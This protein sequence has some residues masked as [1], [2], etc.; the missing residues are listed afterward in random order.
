MCKIAS[1]LVAVLITI[2]ACQPSSAQP[3]IRTLLSQLN[4]PATSDRAVG[5]ILRKTQEDPAAKSYV[6]ENLPAVIERDSQE[7]IQLNAIKLAGELRSPAFVPSLV[8]V[9]PHSPY[10]PSILTFGR[11][12]SLDS[13]PVGKALCVIG[14]PAVPA[15]A[16]LMASETDHDTRWRA[17]RILRNI[18]TSSSRTAL[19]ED[20]KSET[21]PRIK[22][23]ATDNSQP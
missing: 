3:D 22:S 2:M 21:D 4:Q 16:R 11:A 23:L 13:D 9:L 15:L 17:A 6:V 20:L 14:D 7:H 10:K 5:L 19:S 18:D 1:S 8:R 12:Q